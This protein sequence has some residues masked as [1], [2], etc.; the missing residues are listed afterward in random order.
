MGL[1]EPF[2]NCTFGQTRRIHRALINKAIK[3][4][5]SSPLSNS[6]PTSTQGG[7]SVTA[8][9]SLEDFIDIKTASP[10]LEKGPVLAYRAW[11]NESQTPF[12]NGKFVAGL[13]AGRRNGIVPR[14]TPPDALWYAL[15]LA[16]LNKKGGTGK[17]T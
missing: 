2:A 11:D 16:H 9:D 17:K 7:R 1:F 12:R 4:A 3:E 15:A 10:A 5:T 14:T 6:S 13:F 8:G